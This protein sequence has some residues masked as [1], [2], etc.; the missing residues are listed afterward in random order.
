M[1]V[2]LIDGRL[3]FGERLVVSFHRT[4]RLPDDDHTYPL[5]P[6]LG[7]LPILMRPEAGIDVPIFI[8]PLYRREAL[9]L[10]FSRRLGSRMR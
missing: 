8:V 1:N 3:R 4:L 9:W 2:D 10:G 7:L 6:G 5:P